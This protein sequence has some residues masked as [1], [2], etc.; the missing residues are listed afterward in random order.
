MEG[1]LLFK[2][3]VC[4]CHFERACLKESDVCLRRTMDKCVFI[5]KM[6]QYYYGLGLINN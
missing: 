5:K 3:D 4:L 1:K 2:C 6:Q